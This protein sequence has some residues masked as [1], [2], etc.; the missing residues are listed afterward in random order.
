MPSQWSIR[1][2]DIIHTDLWNVSERR[3]SVSVCSQLDFIKVIQIY[4]TNEPIKRI[5]HQP[6]P[7]IA[8]PLLYKGFDHII[9]TK[10]D[11]MVTVNLNN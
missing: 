8:L 5:K 1:L 6:F 4:E 10:R 3:S 7:Y 9:I 11:T 2:A